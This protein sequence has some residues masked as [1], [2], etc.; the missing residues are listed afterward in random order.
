MIEYSSRFNAAPM[1]SG[2]DHPDTSRPLTVT[3]LS[4]YLKQ[5]IEKGFSEVCLQ[6]EISGSKCHSSGHTYFSLK[7]EKATLDAIC[8]RGTR[9]PMALKDGVMVV[10]RGKITTYGAR[11]KYQIIVSSLEPAGQGALLERIDALRKKLTEEGLFALDRKRAL[12]L[13]PRTIAL[14][15]SPTGAVIQDML[16]RFQERLPCRLVL[17]PVNVQGPRT[18]PDILQALRAC[19]TYTPTPDLIIIARGGGSTE[20]L[21]PF[22]DEH[23]VRAVAASPIPIISAIGHETD[24]TLIDYAADRRAP[25]P[26]A[27]AEMAL[28]LVC[29]VQ[30]RINQ[31]VQTLHKQALYR[32]ELAHTRMKAMAHT[33]QGWDTFYWPLAQ[34]LDELHALLA[35]HLKD[36]MVQCQ[37]RLALVARSLGHTPLQEIRQQ[38]QRLEN[39]DQRL[40]QGIQSFVRNEGTRLDHVVRLLEPLSYQKTLDRGFALVTSPAGAVCARKEQ[41]E[42]Q[43]ALRV[44]FADGVLTVHANTPV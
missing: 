31:W 38:K 18:V 9:L 6:G 11:S 34:R 27:A 30:D 37:H 10:C 28:P 41:A 35:R 19:A 4:S 32:Y 5:Y 15:T 24:T 14:I 16:N 8:W 29:H 33:I 25:T 23:L 42:G 43:D 12:P 13:F 40:T 44:R 17:C 21:W 26:T 39:W 1:P 7:D 36:Q 20:D 2:L 22:H 3:Q